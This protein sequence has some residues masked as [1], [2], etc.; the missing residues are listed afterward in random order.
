MKINYC[1]ICRT[2]IHP[3]AKLC[4]RCGKYVNRIDIRNR[5][6]KH[7][8]IKALKDAWD[9][10]H[11]KCYYSGIAL[12]E[13]N[14]KSDAPAKSHMVLAANGGHLVHSGADAMNQRRTIDRKAA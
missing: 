9:G 1:N 10:N 2:S 11:F 6:N 7:A 4:K 13:I 3:L 12:E 5:P 14:S 8:R